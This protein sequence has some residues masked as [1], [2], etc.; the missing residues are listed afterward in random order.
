MSWK[1]KWSTIDSLGKLKISKSSYVYIVL[2]PIL[3]KVFENIENPLRLVFGEMTFLF[4][5]HGTLFTLVRFSL[6]LAQQSTRS[7]ARK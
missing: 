5:F 2:V 6:L 1:Q 3:T 4:H 7:V